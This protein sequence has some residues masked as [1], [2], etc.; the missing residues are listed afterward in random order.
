[1]LKLEREGINSS[2]KIRF[3]YK[4]KGW[5]KNL[6]LAFIIALTFHLAGFLFI[7][8]SPL[9]VDSQVVLK[10]IHV[11]FDSEQIINPGKLMIEQTEKKYPPI[12][13][14][15]F[16]IPPQKQKAEHLIE[17]YSK[18]TEINMYHSPL[19]LDLKKEISQIVLL[20]NLSDRTLLEP[21]KTFNVNVLDLEKIINIVYHVKIDEKTGKIFWYK[22]VQ[23]IN[24]KWEQKVGA[25]F[26]TLTF[27]T[28]TQEIIT[29]GKL[30][31]LIKL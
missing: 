5:T 19:Q 25:I 27:K 17:A 8:I 9:L 16:P 26:Q 20:D 12:Y 14:A 31:V 29:E 6:L 22:P 10:P 15:A 18:D 21:I 2:I 30:E 3:A 24:E 7:R 4:K 11:D 13:L 28:N 1:M 23:E